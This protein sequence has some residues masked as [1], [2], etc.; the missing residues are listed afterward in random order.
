MHLEEVAAL[1][2]ERTG[3]KDRTEELIR[4]SMGE[5]LSV[6]I[7]SGVTASVKAEKRQ[8]DWICKGSDRR[9]DDIFT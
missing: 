9:C 2:T 5:C 1:R 3:K 8:T 7:I 6:W 4:K